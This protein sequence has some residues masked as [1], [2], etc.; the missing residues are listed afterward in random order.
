MIPQQELAYRFA[1]GDDPTDIPA[2][3][4]VEVEPSGDPDS[5]YEA[6]IVGYNW[7]MYA[8]R[9][10]EGSVTLFTGWEG[11]SR[12]TAAQLSALKSGFCRAGV[13]FEEIDVDP[14][15]RSERKAERDADHR[16]EKHPNDYPA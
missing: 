11:Y 13:E 9:T 8:A 12:S 14:K 1:R 15:F 2:A 5:G 10:P 3:S 4:N 6:V 16:I 7:A